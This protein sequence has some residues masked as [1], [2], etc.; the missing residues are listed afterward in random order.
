MSVTIMEAQLLALLRNDPDLAARGCAAEALTAGGL[1]VLRAGHHRGIWAWEINRFTFM[2][3]GYSAPNFD[4][5]TAVEALIHT[6]NVVC[7]GR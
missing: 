4:V 6:R 7:P 3:G 2:P 5:D 1:G